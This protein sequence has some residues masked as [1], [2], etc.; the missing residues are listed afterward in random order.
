MNHTPRTIVA[1]A[2]TIVTPSR[3]ATTRS[4]NA[5]LLHDD[6]VDDTEAAVGTLQE[7]QLIEHIHLLEGKSTAST[8]TTPVDITTTTTTTTTRCR[9]NSPFPSA[10]SDSF[11]SSRSPSRDRSGSGSPCWW[12]LPDQPF[13]P[14]PPHHWA[15]A[16]AAPPSSSP[17]R[18]PL[19]H[20]PTTAVVARK[21]L[22]VDT[23]VVASFPADD[24]R[25]S[26]PVRG[27]RPATRGRRFS[28]GEGG[29]R[30][31][32]SGAAMAVPRAEAQFARFDLADFLRNT[33]P[34]GCGGV[35]AAKQQR[36]GGGG[37]AG[38][39]SALR[40]LGYRRRKSL[41]E[42]VGTVEG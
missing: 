41:A 21:P 36:K 33:G 16:P 1:N 2:T 7:P 10:A 5:E 6:G 28:A 25:P 9:K 42:R 37:K 31:G 30:R 40:F 14:D 38:R 32:G 8:T 24:R 12:S 15:A 34:E 11:S 29:G 27:A 17:A 23:S 20:V 22:R 18:S 3:T 39:R 13:W 26:L 19:L 4:S 35:A